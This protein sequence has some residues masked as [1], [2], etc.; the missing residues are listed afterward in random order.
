MKPTRTVKTTDTL[1]TIIQELQK[2]DGAGVT[3]LANEIGMA[4]STVYDHL[5]TLR[6]KKYVVKDGGT[7]CLSLRFLDHGVY[8]REQLGMNDIIEPAIEQLAIETDESVWFVIEEHGQAV[9]L[10]K[11]LGKRA[12]QIYARI[13]RRLYLHHLAAGKAILANL[14]H[15]RVEEIIDQNGLPAQ[16]ENTITDSE[17]LF[18]ELQTIH[19]EGVAYERNETAIG[20]SS[21][22]APV[23]LGSTVRGAVGVIGPSK[24]IGGTQLQNSLPEM[25][26]GVTNEIELKLAHH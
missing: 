11:A 15:E 20:V 24:R 12:V 13:G 1:F 4:K 3:E 17:T 19:K 26:Q 22:A 23:L 8:A 2:R 16:T 21:I 7:Y 18:S 25:I 14:P 9:F 6:R 10:S 5:T